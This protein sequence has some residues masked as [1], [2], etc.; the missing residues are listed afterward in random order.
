[1][2]W[3]S[4]TNKVVAPFPKVG[5]KFA[6]PLQHWYV[7]PFY[8][9]MYENVRTHARSGGGDVTLREVDPGTHELVEGGL[10]S[11]IDIRAFDT[12]STQEYYSHLVGLDFLLDFHYFLQLRGKLY[13][14]TNHDLWTLR[15]IGSVMFSAHMGIAAYFEYTEKITVTNMYFLV[16][17]AILFSPEG[18]ME[19]MMARR[20]RNGG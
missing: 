14:N 1:M 9:L 10:E 18:F 16:G 5:V 20:H 4:V 13:Y 7:Q 12:K 17:P 2:P 15:L 6:L 3:I 19:K 8:S 11:T